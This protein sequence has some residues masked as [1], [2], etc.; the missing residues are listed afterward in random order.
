MY[1]VCGF[2]NYE[3]TCGESQI[4]GENLTLEDSVSLFLSLLKDIDSLSFNE[5]D[6]LIEEWACDYDW[7]EDD[8]YSGSYGGCI[9]LYDQARNAGDFD[10]EIVL[11]RVER[12][13]VNRT[14][15]YGEIE[16]GAEIT[17]REKEKYLC[18]YSEQGR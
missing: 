1:K 13:P 9:I 15:R 6:S 8:Y 5:L 10:R 16:L 12:D 18:M 17:L 2:T 14:N 7:D 4:F 3:C 11:I